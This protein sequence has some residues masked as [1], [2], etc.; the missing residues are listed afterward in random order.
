MSDWENKGGGPEFRLFD[1]A[2]KLPFLTRLFL[3]D[4][5]HKKIA[6]STF[7]Q[8]VGK[9]F[10]IFLGAVTLKMISNFLSANDYGI[11]ASIA[12]YA[13]FF[14]MVAN[15]G[16]FGNTVRE[17]SRK[18]D[19]GKTFMNSLLLRIFTAGLFFGVGIL[20][21]MV[22]GSEQVFLIGTALFMGG[23]FFDYV[24]SVCDGML[25]AN[26]LM[27]RA[28]F[29]LIAGRVINVGAVYFFINSFESG[30]LSIPL[31]FLAIGAGSFVT[32]GLSLFFVS[33][34]IKFELQMDRGFMF[35]ILKASLPFGIINIINSLYFRFLPDL[36]S[37]GVL[38]DAEFATFNISFK[39]AQVLSLFSTF[40]MFSVLPGFKR[41]LVS[42]ELQKAGNMYKKIQLLLAV[43]GLFV[44]FAG[45]LMGPFM[46]E[47]LTHKKYFLPDFWFVLP[48]M[49]LLC[50]VSYFYDL[51]LISLFA[52]NRE[53]WFLKME[54]V[55]LT[56]A[57]IVFGVA[58]FTTAGVGIKLLL[59]II[60]AI[61]GEL[62]MVIG[63]SMNVGKVLPGYMDTNFQQNLEVD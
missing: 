50:A 30:M 63:A 47:V 9:V 4:S 52:L 8:I 18:P 32:A 12:E 11:Y 61:L 58:W 51:V 25:Q 29:A 54:L 26:Y 20:Y 33:R 44:V 10:Q 60:G 36:L 23:L 46:L 13:L 15:L 21:L 31:L 3:S 7:V 28:V 2:L 34:I 55:A 45:S 40:L 22:S 37:R 57:L 24:T 6:V 53:I 48:L 56:L 49:L 1:Y 41:Y 19:C 5:L 17:M 43:C 14:S 16:I 35:N 39:I 38:S 62:A 59:I 27:G 42:G